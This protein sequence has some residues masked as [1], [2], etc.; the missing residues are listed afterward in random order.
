MTRKQEKRFRDLESFVSKHLYS[1]LVDVCPDLKKQGLSN[2]YI[3]NL[4]IHCI[5]E[6]YEKYIDMWLKGF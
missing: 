1:L 6:T 5:N 2:E 4:L 3:D